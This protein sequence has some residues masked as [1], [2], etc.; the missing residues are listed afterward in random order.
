MSEWC[1][2]SMKVFTPRSRDMPVFAKPGQSVCQLVKLFVAI[3]LWKQLGV[4]QPVWYKWHRTKMNSFEH[5]DTKKLMLGCRHNNV[6]AR[7]NLMII[8]LTVLVAPCDY[9]LGKSCPCFL[10]TTGARA[11]LSPQTA[12][13]NGTPDAC[14]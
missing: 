2:E 9:V 14:K 11:Y 8:R 5:G 3:C 12:R 4:G 6:S 1:R 13:R 7:E 10:K